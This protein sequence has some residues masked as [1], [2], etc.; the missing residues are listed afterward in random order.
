DA[1]QGGAQQLGGGEEAAVR[2]H[3]PHRWYRALRR[4][5]AE[6][7][8]CRVCRLVCEAQPARFSKFGPE[9][10][11]HRFTLGRGE[12][13]TFAPDKREASRR[14]EGPFLQLVGRVVQRNRE[15]SSV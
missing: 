12:V 11:E 14:E 8:R 15:Y 2:A 7:A 10:A 3:S 5:A 6:R 4:S 9:A 13:D 1:E